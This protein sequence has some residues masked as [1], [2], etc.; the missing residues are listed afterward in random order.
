MNQKTRKQR[1]NTI[2]RRNNKRRQRKTRVKGGMYRKL[3]NNGYFTEKQEYEAEKL[4]RKQKQERIETLRKLQNG[5][6][7]FPNDSEIN[8]SGN[9]DYG[10]NEF[11]NDSKI[12]FSDF[13]KKSQQEKRV[14]LNNLPQPTASNRISAL[15]DPR[16]I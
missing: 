3:R 12:N 13:N 5:F 15:L 1:R 6:N 16:F 14:P 11:P 2:R 8:F 4:L 9:L 10:F 7:E